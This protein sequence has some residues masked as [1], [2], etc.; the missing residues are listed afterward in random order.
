M[1]RRVW[2]VGVL[3]VWLSSAPSP[4]DEA[5]PRLKHHQPGL[6]VDLGVG[7]WAW[8]VPMDTDGDGDLDLLVVCPDVPFNGTYRFENPDGRVRSPVFRPGVRVG[9]GRHDVMPSYVD[10]KVCVLVPGREVMDLATKGTAE[11]RAIYL[12]GNVHKKGR[13]TRENQWRQVDYDGDGDLDLIAGVADWTDYGWDDAFD[14]HGRWMRGPLHAYLYLIR[15]RGSD[16][17]PDYETPRKIEAGGR[18]LD[19]YG[20]PSPNF[21]DFDGDGDLDL[22]CGEFLDRLTYFENV[23]T[24]TEPEYR[25]GRAVL[26]P[27]G[28]PI[29]MDLQMI[30]PV[31][32]DWDGDG[33]TDLVIGDEDGR[34]ALVEHTG[35]LIDGTPRFRRPSYFRQEADDVKFGSLVTPS[36]AD[37]DGDGDTDLIVGNSAGYL[38]F[39]ANL[40][41]DPVHWAEPVRLKAGGETIRIQAGPSGSIQGPCEAKWGYT[42]PCV[43]DW[44][45]DGRLD[46]VVN[47]I[48]GTVVW[49]RNVGVATSP[50][51]APAKPIAVDWPGE[52]PKPAWTWWEPEGRQL[53]TQWRTTPF[54]IDLNDDGR[55]DLVLLDPEGYLAFFERFHQADG[56]LGL[57]PG[58]RIFRTEGP[59]GFDSKQVIKD[60]E[61]GLL[62][63]NVGEAGASGRRKFCL[64][65]WDGDGD[66]DLIVNSTSANLLRNV[67]TEPGEFLFRDEGPLTTQKLAGHTTCPTIGDLDGDGRPE[68]ILGAEDG[69][70]Y[71]LG[72]PER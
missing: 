71:D 15:N 67:S 3:S 13:R 11:S 16:A 49:Y 6:T 26:D 51:L 41:G 59:S 46:I 38:G 55:N 69:H 28:R 48:W 40:G 17:K 12:S 23:G 29:V 33:D 66:L 24:R 68:L 58:R 56:T 21:A 32:I 31:A 45:G 47:S 37:W 63:L 9:P 61:P 52:T 8:P 39:I 64:A 34:V 19:V 42:V 44:D 20:R 5:I 18:V 57:R 4:A 72:H 14:A 35:R 65:D 2:A 30:V 60:S 1:G 25:R 27:E 53:V 43:A 36:A 7:L 50:A 70:L 10:G 54:V 22:I 62:R